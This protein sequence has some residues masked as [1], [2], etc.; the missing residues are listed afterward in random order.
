MK[1]CQKCS[2]NKSL[3]N[4]GK[5]KARKDGLTCYCK[6]C[7]SGIQKEFRSKRK[8]LLIE[9]SSLEEK[10]TLRSNE[11]S[12]SICGV[13]KKDRLKFHRNFRTGDGLD[14]CCTACEATRIRFKR[15]G[16]TQQDYENL[17]LKQNGI[18]AICKLSTILVV[19]HDHQTLRVRGLLC[20]PCNS[21]LGLFKESKSVL[22]QAI[23][24]LK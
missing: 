17:L 3:D 11:G 8:E 4:F 9:N 1:F 23:E 16:I 6:V 22:F 2:K 13:S 14:S 15:Y 19:D 18:C 10:W 24:Y 12:C 5:N 20:S 21:A 7:S